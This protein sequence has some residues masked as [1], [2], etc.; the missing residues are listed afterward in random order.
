MTDA[1]ALLAR[2]YG[3]PFA[4][5]DEPPD[6]PPPRLPAGSAAVLAFG[7][8]ASRRV[9]AGKLGGAAASVGVLDAR[10]SGVDVVYSAHVA[11]YGA[12]PA[13]L[14]PSPGTTLVA[15]LLVVAADALAVLDAT[16]PNY[17]RGPLG[18][19]ARVEVPGL[20]PVVTEAYASRHGELVLDG[21]PVALAAVGA[22]GRALPARA[23]R[24][25]HRAVRDLLEP[26]ADLDAFVLAGARDPEIRAGRTARLRA[27]R[28]AARG[29]HRRE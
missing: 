15:R 5:P 13:T 3:Y 7:A 6:A 9:L 12:I 21:A 29:A 17:V 16:E 14:H 1:A 10:V 23:Q 4:A 20:G 2:A 22:E 25:V 18:P 28:E 19:E 8:N 24:D 11:P 26:G 27:L